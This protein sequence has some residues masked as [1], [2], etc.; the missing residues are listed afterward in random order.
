[1]LKFFIW[2]LLAVNLGLFAYQQGYLN[3]LFPDGREPA[4]MAQQVNADKITLLPASAVVTVQAA[5]QAA[6][7][8]AAAEAPPLA[9]IEIG[10]FDAAAAKRFETALAPLALGARLVR[11]EVQDAARNIVY[12]P[13]QGSKDG[14]DRKATE[15]RHLGVTEFYIM[16]DAGEFRW[17]I[18]LGVF[19]T[20]EAAR[21]QL[22]ALGQKGVH[23]ARLGTRNAAN[24]GKLAYQLHN[25]DAADKTG[26]D[27]LIVDF[28]SSQQRDCA[29]ASTASGAKATTAAAPPVSAPPKN[30]AARLSA[31]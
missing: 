9:C 16:Q 6:A 15:L 22:A 7:Q 24:S 23:S 2:T 14:A 26:L 3:S 11:H 30:G 29:A 25:L 1:M 4:R 20:E 28:P 12:I 21:A 13:S 19:K 8:T 18:S 27:K 5:A 17:A 31:R 10:D